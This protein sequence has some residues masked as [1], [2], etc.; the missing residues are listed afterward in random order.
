MIRFG[1]FTLSLT[2]KEDID[3]DMSPI[4]MCDFVRHTYA[5]HYIGYISVRVYWF[6]IYGQLTYVFGV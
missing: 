2:L 5:C 6:T 4:K 3:L 1:L